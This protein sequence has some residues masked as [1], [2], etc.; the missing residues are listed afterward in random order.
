VNRTN[1][2]AAAF[3]PARQAIFPCIWAIAAFTLLGSDRSSIGA[4]TSE[5]PN[6]V[7][8]V[9]D[10][11]RWDML[12][13]AGNP[14][15]STPNVDKLA[16]EGVHFR[17]MFVTTAICAASRASL[18]TGLY[19][20]THRYTFGTKP[21]TDAHVD[22]S[23]PAQL[24]K[25]GYRTGFVGKFGVGVER[26]ATGRM[27]DS[28]V[29]LNRTPYWK[30][31]P[32]GTEKHLT[33]IEGEKAI[34]FLEAAKTGKPFCLSIC[35]NAPHAEDEDPKQY[36]WQKEV[37]RL[38]ADTTFPVPKTMTDD[39]FNSH[40]AFLKNSESRVRFKWRFD[41]PKK[42]QEMV[43]GY[44]RMISGVDLVVG[45][46]HD[47]LKRL[48]L[49]DNTV[50]IFT[51]DNGYF[52]G[53]RG[54]ADKWYMYEQSI[55]VPLIVFDPRAKQADRGRVVDAM[56]LNVDL[57]P[58]VLE[59]ARIEAPK[60]IQGHSLVPLLAGRTPAD[61]R[62]DFFYEHLFERNNIPKSEGVRNERFTYLRWFE[63][64]PMVEEL[65]D[66]V[67]DFE[68]TKNLVNDPQYSET[69]KKLR[70]RTMELRDLYGGPYRPN[71]ATKE[72]N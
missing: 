71:L 18:L 40:P 8:I 5:R 41:E 38:Y 67:A 34:A 66:H 53:D 39:F 15:I 36:F 59:L 25:S 20:R 46:V 1:K 9:T 22:L 52:L 64:N 72:K 70:K 42:Y 26:G 55:R 2:P 45:R 3:K 35:F 54:F 19:E 13:C 28:F 32:D 10:D 6:F 44:Y 62:S 56:A 49:A 24:K 30:K 69:L 14:I 23:Y 43:R 33:D 65:Y 50:L 63:Q 31:Q 61:W 58:T 51:S 57:S 16:K 27:F 48:G 47:A 29:P 60:S 17:N 7:F 21:I 37:D 4:E 68:E 12:G 11:Q